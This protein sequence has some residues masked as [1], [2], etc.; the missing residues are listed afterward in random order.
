MAMVGVFGVVAYTVTQRTHE[1]GIRMALGAQTSD[2]VRM[3]A[4]K[5]VVLGA[6]G[7]GIG[8]ALAAPLVWLPTGGPPGMPLSERVRVV[9]AAGVLLWVAALLASYIPARR[10]TRI[11]PTV[12]L[13]YE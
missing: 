7:V 10:A 6:V 12:A 4:T 8:L 9:L 2:V 1:I 5:G 3:V 11:D 13:R